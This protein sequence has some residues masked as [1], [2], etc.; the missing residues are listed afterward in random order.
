MATMWLIDRQQKQQKKT[1]KTGYP[2]LE[3]A[4]LLRRCAE[5]RFP[6]YDRIFEAC[7]DTCGINS[8]QSKPRGGVSFNQILGKCSELY[9]LT[10]RVA[11]Q[12]VKGNY[13][14]REKDTEERKT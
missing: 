13:Q 10:A 8:H 12:S 4:H 6:N 3:Q 7:S 14:E 2:D 5:R 11:V 9:L 1:K